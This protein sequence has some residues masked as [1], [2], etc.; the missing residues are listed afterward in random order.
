MPVA[1]LE[2]LAR[3]WY[4]ELLEPTFPA[5]ELVL[6]DDFV[7]AVRTG[8]VLI[9][10]TG[11][12]AHPDGIAIAE[13]FHE[14]GVLLLS[15]L[16]VRP[17][18]RGGGVGQRLLAEALQRWQTELHP[19]LVL[20]EVEHP[21]SVPADQAH[22]DPVARL[23]FYEAFGA[24]AINLPY[25][26]QPLRPGGA[27]LEHLMLVAFR[28][29]GRGPGERIDREPLRSFLLSYLPGR[30]RP[31]DRI[32]DALAAAGDQIEAIGLSSEPAQL[33]NPPRR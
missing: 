21:G 6:E 2:S 15:W 17:S 3:T 16:A 27:A 14:S 32:F 1:D 29:E 11:D 33:P 28:V 31:Y 20:G 18:A 8:E 23:R 4:R 24:R 25:V 7:A 30:E 12:Q 26:Q 10:T 19:A 13:Y 22:G 9:H 5:D